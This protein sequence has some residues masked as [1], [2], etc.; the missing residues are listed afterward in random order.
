MAAP[1]GDPRLDGAQ[2]GAHDGRDLLVWQALYIA[3]DEREA[4][5]RDEPLQRGLDLRDG[6]R[7]QRGALGVPR[8]VNQRLRQPRVSARRAGVGIAVGLQRL[9]EGG[10]GT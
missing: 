9:L 4:L 3:Q 2:R 10:G 5:L 7:T 6:L 8:G 1:T